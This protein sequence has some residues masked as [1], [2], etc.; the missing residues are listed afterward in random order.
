M[1]GVSAGVRWITASVF[2]IALMAAGLVLAAL[3]VFADDDP[4]GDLW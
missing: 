3:Q 2:V 1:S 4:V